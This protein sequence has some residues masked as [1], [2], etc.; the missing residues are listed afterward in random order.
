MYT[1]SVPRV[2]DEP[3]AYG[4]HEVDDDEFPA[5]RI[6]EDLARSS[7]QE[8]PRVLARYAALRSWLLREE[9][10]DPVLVRHAAQ[11]A[12]AYLAAVE[13]WPEAGPLARLA[14]AE[15]ALGPVHAAAA[16]AREAG[17]TESA[18][19]LLH[20]G[21]M[22]ARRRADLP[23]AARLAGALADLLAA[24]GMDGAALW[25]RRAAR[26]RQHLDPG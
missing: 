20:A 10:A 24:E 11:T 21:Y 19:A 9:D 26:L 2:R 23:W 15:P 3:A 25:T 18:Y 22:A 4:P 6:L 17:H 16:E 8:V 13:D 5:A 7:D 14:D 1:S 12:R